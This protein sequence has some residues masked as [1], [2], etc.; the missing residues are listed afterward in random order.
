MHLLQVQTKADK[1]SLTVLR[2]PVMELDQEP[3]RL[4]AVL[5]LQLLSSGKE[6]APLS[7]QGQLYQ[8]T[9]QQTGNASAE[10]AQTNDLVPQ[11][12]ELLSPE[13]LPSKLLPLE[14]LPLWQ[15]PSY[16]W[17]LLSQ[18]QLIEHRCVLV[19]TDWRHR[20]LAT[21]NIPL[22]AMD[23]EVLQALK[24]H[25]QQ[26][27]KVDICQAQVVQRPGVQSKFASTMIVERRLSRNIGQAVHVVTVQ[28]Q[29]VSVKDLHAV[30]LH[31]EMLQTVVLHGKMA[32]S[33]AV[34]AIRNPRIIVVLELSRLQL[35]HAIV[36][37]PKVVKLQKVRSVRTRKLRITRRAESASTLNKPQDGASSEP[38]LTRMVSLARVQMSPARPT[39]VDAPSVEETMHHN[40]PRAVRARAER[41]GLRRTTCG[42]MTMAPLTR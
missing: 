40:T 1:K 34:Q 5:D 20:P 27:L 31:M 8:S 26:L 14:L 17:L 13:L 35:T 21:C 9:V 29:V 41:A 6:V 18:L 12:V 22:L 24:Y 10:F 36:V 30:Y 23:P 11:P 4:F 33:E 37:Q 19:L 39:P 16:L 25:L 2:L 32:H 7:V 28:F 42:Q 3:L 15:R 38:W